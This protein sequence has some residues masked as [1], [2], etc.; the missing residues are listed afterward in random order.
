MTKKEELM[1]QIIGRLSTSDAPLVFKGALIIKLIL[2]DRGYTE[3]ERQTRD[4]DANWV[5]EPPSMDDMVDAV[6]RSLGDLRNQ[7][8]AVAFRS[9]GDKM[10]AGI[11]IRDKSTDDEVVS[12]DIDMRPIVGSRIYHYG[13]ISIRGV[14]VNEILSDKIAVLSKKN[15]F[16]RAKDLIDVYAL[17]HCV[18]VKTSDIFGMF[19]KNPD[20][21]IGPFTEFYTRRQDVEHAYG[22]LAGVDGKPPFD[23]VYSYLKA[24]IQPFAERDF[25]PRVWS[26]NRLIWN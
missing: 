2:S 20:R 10:S 1:Y 14:L 12:M 15:I 4:I 5:G 7:F 21:E 11:Y 24:F 9:Y 16:R 23:E 18:N 26:S 22:R 6:D 25:T 13:D 8:H 19:E 17:A 3:M